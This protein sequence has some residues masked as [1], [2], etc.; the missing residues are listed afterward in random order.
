VLDEPGDLR[1]AQKRRGH[2]FALALLALDA[3]RSTPCFIHALFFLLFGQCKR[4]LQS[5]GHE[6]SGA[7][8]VPEDIERPSERTIALDAG[9]GALR[10]ERRTT[11]PSLRTCRTVARTPRRSAAEQRRS[12]R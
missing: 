5:E 10:S 4:P 8:I 9:I 12:F 11:T 3:E 7:P 6:A 2:E 1:I